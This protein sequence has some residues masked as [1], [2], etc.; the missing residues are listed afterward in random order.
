MS[1]GTDARAESDPDYGGVH[2]HEPVELAELR[3]EVGELT[4]RGGGRPVHVARGIPL[5]QEA[6]PARVRTHER[7]L[8]IELLFDRS[9]RNGAEFERMLVDSGTPC[10]PRRR[11]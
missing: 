1:A 4:N 3:E 2:K 9:W 7:R 10:S 5:R 8:Q 6:Q 11:N